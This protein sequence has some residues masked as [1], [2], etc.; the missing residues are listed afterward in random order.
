MHLPKGFNTW[1]EFNLIII[2]AAILALL[3]TL[4]IIKHINRNK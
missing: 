4:G 3:V 2:E 1:N